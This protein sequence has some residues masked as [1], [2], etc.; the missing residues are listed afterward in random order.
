MRLREIIR[1][2]GDEPKNVFEKGL[3]AFDKTAGAT[4]IAPPE[5]SISTAEFIQESLRLRREAKRRILNAA[6]GGASVMKEIKQ[7]GFIAVAQSALSIGS[8]IVPGSMDKL[9]HHDG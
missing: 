4:F 9:R 3:E 6:D 1:N 8:M 2:L 5:L 7:P